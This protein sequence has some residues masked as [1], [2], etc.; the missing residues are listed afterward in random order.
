[1]SEHIGQRIR[2]LREAADLSQA[3]V[4]ARSRVSRSYLSRIETGLMTPGLATLEKL[5]AALDV[6]LRAFFAPETDAAVLLAD[7]WIRQ[8]APYVRQITSEQRARMTN[9]LREFGKAA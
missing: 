2:R 1:M 4:T 9:L 5:G 3:R 6:P 7:P 8:I